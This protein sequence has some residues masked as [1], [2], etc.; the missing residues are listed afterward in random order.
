MILLFLTV[1]VPAKSNYTFGNDLLLDS[2]QRISFI[3][4]NHLRIIFLSFPYHT[5]IINDVEL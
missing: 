1:Q 5:S 3:L 2:C 4:C